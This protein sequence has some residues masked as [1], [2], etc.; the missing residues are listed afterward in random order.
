MTERRKYMRFDVNFNVEYSFPEGNLEE[1]HETQTTNISKEGIRLSA[2]NP[3]LQ[4]KQLMLKVFLP[5]DKPIFALGEIAWCEN[6]EKTCNK[7]STGVKFT[8]INFLDKSKLFNYIYTKWLIPDS[9]YIKK[10][11]GI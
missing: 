4:G 10:M 5:D 11:G 7:Y 3:M 6:S 9:G 1:K 8:K 2:S